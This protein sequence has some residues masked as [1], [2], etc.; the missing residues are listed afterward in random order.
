MNWDELNGKLRRV[1]PELAPGLP[2]SEVQDICEYVDHDEP[3]LA[4]EM[5]CT[6]LYEHDAG[7]RSET[8][9]RLAELGVAM[10]LDP[11]QWQ[12]LRVSP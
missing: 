1:V 10:G 9:A 12:M 11:R 4:F 3:G 5:L 2:V 8:V 7:I 6:Q